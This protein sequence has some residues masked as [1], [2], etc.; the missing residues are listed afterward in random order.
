MSSVKSE[1]YLL[2]SVVSIQ[3]KNRNDHETQNSEGDVNK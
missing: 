2:T 3:R 1:Q